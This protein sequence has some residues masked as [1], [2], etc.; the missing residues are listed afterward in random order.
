MS[1]TQVAAALGGEI[2]SFEGG[3]EV[4]LNEVGWSCGT[5]LVSALRHSKACFLSSKLFGNIL[6]P[7]RQL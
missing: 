7:V 1:C 5:Q 3:H 4:P 2:Y 6:H